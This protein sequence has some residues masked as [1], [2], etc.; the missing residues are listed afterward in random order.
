[1]HYFRDNE[2]NI[3]FILLGETTGIGGADEGD[4]EVEDH[5]E[6]RSR[7]FVNARLQLDQGKIYLV[8]QLE[9]GCRFL[10]F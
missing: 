1:M 8:V 5:P 3:Y 7:E 9:N 2:Y 6:E 4:D 10:K